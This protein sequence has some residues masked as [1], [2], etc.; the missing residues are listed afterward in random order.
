MGALLVRGMLCGLLAGLLVFAFLRVTGEPSVERA[1]AFESAHEG[2]AHDHGA[3]GH[4][5]EAAAEPGAETTDVELVSRPVQAGWG[6]L[7]GV[8]TYAVAFGGLF[9]LAFGAA[10]GRL[11]PVTP[12]GTAALVGAMG[13]VAVSLVPAMIYPANPPS[14]G[15]AG[16]I[17]MRTAWFFALIALSL[18]ALLL[19]VKLRAMLSGSLGSWNATVVA[20]LGYGILMAVAALALPAVHETPDGFPAD[21]LWRFRLASLGS[22]ALLWAVLGLGFGALAARIL[23]GGPSRRAA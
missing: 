9:A 17:G 15:D 22:Q 16:T 10:H 23:P 13:F 20:A 19:A 2:H 6:L 5:G 12:R 7:T 21:L 18:A 1:I 3:A 14:I 4:G 8:M 11:P